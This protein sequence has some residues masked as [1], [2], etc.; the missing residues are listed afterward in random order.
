M[1]IH[2]WLAVIFAAVSVLALLAIP[3]SAAGWITPDPLS[4]V[5]A[6]LLGLPWSVLLLWL[7][8]TDALTI[9]FALVAVSLAINASLLWLLGRTIS[10]HWRR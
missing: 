8:D 2:P 7:V 5:P 9:N 6:I 4:A 10:R 3:S 1:R